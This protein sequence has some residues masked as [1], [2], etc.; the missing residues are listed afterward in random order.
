MTFRLRTSKRRT[1][2]KLMPGDEKKD[3]KAEVEY[4]LR[5]IAKIEKYGAKPNTRNTWRHLHRRLVLRMSWIHLE[6]NISREKTTLAHRVPPTSWLQPV[7]PWPG[8][9]AGAGKGVALATPIPNR[10][11]QTS[12]TPMEI[13]SVFSSGHTFFDPTRIVT[14][15]HLS[16]SI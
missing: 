16:L 3:A 10:I 13:T 2:Q 7:G 6:Y 8:P 9:R 5:W 1:E 15:P 12:R 11:G 14:A 4:E